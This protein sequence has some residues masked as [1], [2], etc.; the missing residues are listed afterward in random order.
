M[1]DL[2][3]SAIMKTLRSI[4]F[5]V[6]I[7]LLVGC[8]STRKK[9]TVFRGVTISGELYRGNGNSVR[10]LFIE[11]VP[12]TKSYWLGPWVTIQQDTEPGEFYLV[13]GYNR[14]YIQ[15]ASPIESTKRFYGPFTGRPEDV[16][17]VYPST[18]LSKE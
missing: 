3:R 9:E 16:F 11:D 6:S 1:S 13:T 8:Q 4:F 2:K 10:D 14:F 15:T 17:T 7:V 18:G 5:L 12:G